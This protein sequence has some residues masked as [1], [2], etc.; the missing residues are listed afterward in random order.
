MLSL[1]VTYFQKN[2]RKLGVGRGQFDAGVNGLMVIFV[3]H[4]NGHSPYKR[5]VQ[6][7]GIF[8]SGNECLILDQAR[9]ELVL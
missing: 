1:A 5:A 4:F 7:H 9:L 6:T 2:A 8:I 3:D